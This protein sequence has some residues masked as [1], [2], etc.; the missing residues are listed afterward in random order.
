M[1]FKN[2]RDDIISNMSDRLE[3]VYRLGV[4]AGKQQAINRLK[5]VLELG[6]VEMIGDVPS[7]VEVEHVPPPPSRND[8]STL[9]SSSRRAPRGTPRR[10]INRI[11]SERPDGVTAYDIQKFAETDDE[12]L[13]AITSIRDKLRL[14]AKDGVYLEKDGLWFFGA[15]AERISDVDESD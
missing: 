13:V 14:G 11:L 9:G 8:D 4:E 7:G 2:L 15:N 1:S 12:K 10:L 3:E 6:P 5:Q